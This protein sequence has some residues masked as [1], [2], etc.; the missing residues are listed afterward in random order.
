MTTTRNEWTA[1]LTDI[2]GDTT[3]I[4]LMTLV[5][6]ERIRADLNAGCATLAVTC[7]TLE[8]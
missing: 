5:A 8:T 2:D 3:D 1:I 7:E 6:S 4:A